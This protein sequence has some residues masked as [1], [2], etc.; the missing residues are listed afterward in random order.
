MDLRIGGRF[1]LGRKIGSGSFGEIYVG[2]DVVSGREVAIKMEPSKTRAPQLHIE[3]R[4]YKVSF[5]KPI[6]IKLFDFKIM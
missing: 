3:T 6:K 2:R 5:R 1:R 4:G